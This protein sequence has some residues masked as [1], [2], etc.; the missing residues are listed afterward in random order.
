MTATVYPT[1]HNAPALHT[2]HAAHFL[3]AVDVSFSW[4]PRETLFEHLTVSFSSNE[5]VALD[6]PSG[7]GKSTLCQLLAGYLSPSAGRILLDGKP[8][9]PTDGAYPVQL[10]WQHPEQAMD[11]Y[12]RIGS[13]LEEAGT[14]DDSL[15]EGLGIQKDWL[16][17]FPHELSGGELQRC[18]IARTLALEPTFLIADEISTMLDALTQAQIWRF[19]LDWCQEHGTG[20]VLV[21]HSDA[22]RTRLATRTLSLD[23]APVP[24]EDE[25]GE[26]A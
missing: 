4:T 19:L 3:E 7:F 6:A 25:P 17:R 15:M 22:L 2:P 12:L 8:I 24:I 10:C 23:S 13:S 11:P 5:R 20:L 9:A 14:V 26:R 1:P 21:T 18:C 16:T